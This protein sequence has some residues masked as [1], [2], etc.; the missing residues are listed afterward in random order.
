MCSAMRVGWQ[1]WGQV[2]FNA[3]QDAGEGN[4]TGVDTP[5]PGEDTSTDWW[6]TDDTA[7]SDSASS[8]SLPLDRWL[9]FQPHD[10]GS[11]SKLL[12]CFSLVAHLAG[13]H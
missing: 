11:R 8:S 13:S 4:G 9:P 5:A 7:D 10:T 2:S 1:E 12:P 3:P 6:E